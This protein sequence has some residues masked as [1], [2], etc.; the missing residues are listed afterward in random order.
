MGYLL[1][2]FVA[3]V[4]IYLLTD[5]KT[6]IRSIRIEGIRVEGTI[7]ENHDGPGNAPFRLGGNLNGPT[8]QFFTLDGHEVIGQPL[9][10]FISQDEVAVP[11]SVY[12]IYSRKNPEKFCIDA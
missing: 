12:I 10:G 3:F 9:I 5:K 11:S 8:I 4:A 1:L 6:E 7:I 2:L